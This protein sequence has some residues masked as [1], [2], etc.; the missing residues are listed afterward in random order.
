MKAAAA[1]AA[2][3]SVS[4]LSSLRSPL[5][6]EEGETSASPKDSVRLCCCSVALPSL[7]QKS[8]GRAGQ[9]TF[10]DG[11]Q[12]TAPSRCFSKWA[13]LLTAVSQVPEMLLAHETN[14]WRSPALWQE[15]YTPISL[16]KFL[17]LP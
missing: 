9:G 1:A 2:A 12:T 15:F 7:V 17:F 13:V 11:H 10:T 6:E 5:E 4:M 3:F 16:K 14:L 8:S